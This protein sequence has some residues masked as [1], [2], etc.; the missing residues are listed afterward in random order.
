MLDNYPQEVQEWLQSTGK[1]LVE[2]N[3]YDEQEI[4]SCI[5]HESYIL[6]AGPVALQSWIENGE[7]RLDEEQYMEVLKMTIVEAVLRSLQ[8]KGL[9]DSMEDH[10]GE[11]VFF[12]TKDGKNIT[13]DTD[14]N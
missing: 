4:D 2:S 5:G 6:Q 12:L 9:I 1:I 11:E 10:A 3:F 8:Q 13:K 7:V 14:K